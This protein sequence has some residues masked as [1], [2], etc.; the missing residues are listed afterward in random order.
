MTIDPRPIGIWSALVLAYVVA[1]TVFTWPL[2]LHLDTHIWGDRFD[3]WTTLWLLWFLHHGVATGTIAELTNLISYPAGYNLWSFGHMALQV[4]AVPLISAGLSVTAAY[5]ILGIGALA[6]TATAG[7]ALGRGLTGSHTG[8]VLAACVLAFN[9]LLYGEFAVGSIELVAAF[10]LPLYVW[11]LVRLAEQPSVKR[12][13]VLAAV[14][15]VTGPFNWYYSIFCILLTP[16]LALLL[17]IGKPWRVSA[18]FAGGLVAAGLVV[19]LL[20]MP[21]FDKIRKE[22]PPRI[23]LSVEVATPEALGRLIDFHDARLELRDLERPELERFDAA[24]AVINS[25][26]VRTLLRASFSVNPLDSTP[27]R[28]AFVMALIGLT[29]CWRKGWRWAVLAALFGLLTLGPFLR[30]DAGSAPGD[31]ARALP[32][33]YY[34]LYNYLPYFSKAYRP[35]RLGIVT[36]TALAALAAYAGPWLRGV[37]GRWGTAGLLLLTVGLFATQPHWSQGQPSKR[38]GGAHRTPAP[39]PTSTSGSGPLSVL[40]DRS[41]PAVA[42]QQPAHP[43]RR[44][45][46]VARSG[47]AKRPDRPTLG[48]RRPPTRPSHPGEDRGCARSARSR[49]Q[50]DRCPRSFPRRSRTLD[51]TRRANGHAASPGLRADR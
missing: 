39:L 6:G 22:T 16:P 12:A 7:H 19:L 20:T 29:A 38:G 30:W 40:S 25:T 32:L 41:R 2:A 48:A 5:N 24:Q 13:A 49:L 50:A 31:G 11:S 37:M 8:G 21:L 27:G 46:G 35:Y 45:A 15:A 17:A 1:A 44:A 34:Y 9:P 18:R 10:F 42:Q 28:L 51:W 4:L 33:P 14:L 47:Q 3:A 23:P 26:T 43:N 36:I